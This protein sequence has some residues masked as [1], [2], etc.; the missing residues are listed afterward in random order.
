M[1]CA[2]RVILTAIPVAIC[3]PDTSSDLRQVRGDHWSEGTIMKAVRQNPEPP[4]PGIIPAAGRWD[5]R[6]GM[7]ASLRDDTGA[8]KPC[9]V[10]GWELDDLSPAEGERHRTPSTGVRRA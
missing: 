5:D 8:R 4:D 7:T 6:L 9:F 10:M 1:L 2:G 3:R